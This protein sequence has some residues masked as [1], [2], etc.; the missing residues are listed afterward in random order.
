[1]V[2]GSTPKTAQL[3][4]N[5][6]MEH[7]KPVLDKNL[8]VLYISFSSGLSGSFNAVR[9]ASEQLMLDYPDAKIEIVDSLCA[10]GGEGL[11]VWMA[12]QK[13][14][15]GAT[16]EEN[17]EYLE[18]LKLHVKHSFTVAD[19][20]YLKRGGRIKATA[21]FAAK[22]LNIK[23]VLHVD[24]EGHLVALSKKHGRRAALNAT[25]ENA[26]VGLDTKANFIT[27]VSHADALE[28]A[29]YCKDYI[30][31]KYAEMHFD[32]KVVITPIGPVIGAHS[33]PGTIAVFTISEK[34][35]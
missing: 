21:A 13:K 25:C 3:N 2:N 6:I 34:R 8:D 27:I 29:L 1:M 32:S 5:Y 7:A 10:S 30:E 16:L 24:N 26:L 23:P 31:K 22:L 4:V 11:L 19:L 9:L 12:V 15:S 35:Q 17:K 33:G 28:D 18:N 20:E 14:N